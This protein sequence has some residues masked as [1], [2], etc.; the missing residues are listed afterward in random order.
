MKIKQLFELDLGN[1]SSGKEW[2]AAKDAQK[3]QGQERAK[4]IAMNKQQQSAGGG[5]GTALATVPNNQ[6]NQVVQQKP[7]VDMGQADQVQNDP[8]VVDVDA[9][10]VPNSKPPATAGAFGNIVN[11]ATDAGQKTSDT[12]PAADQTQ[13]A[14]DAKIVPPTTGAKVFGDMAS[15]LT[16]P[17]QAASQTSSSGGTI[18]KTPTGQTHAASPDNPNQPQTPPATTQTPPGAAAPTQQKQT[19]GGA[20]KNLGGQVLKGVGNAARAA[21]GAVAGAAGSMVGGFAGGV[22]RGYQQQAAGGTTPT[23]N[24]PSGAFAGGGGAQQS[25]GGGNNSNDIQ[26]LNARLA[27][28]EKRLSATHE[29]KL[30]FESKF[31][32]RKI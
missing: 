1:Y 4:Q 32:G 6:Q 28:I 30:Q 18:T 7:A 10:E 25:G 26:Q 19:F 8:N 2:K 27:N 3:A 20:L 24:T 15:Q 5:P 29:G 17:D 12:E 16:K 13:Q 23:W 9:K 31:L 22:K 14:T 11:T 21:P